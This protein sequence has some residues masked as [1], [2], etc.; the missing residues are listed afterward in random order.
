MK[1]F[2]LSIAILMVIS[3]Y[4]SLPTVKADAAPGDRIVVLGEDLTSQQQNE[5]LEEMGV[6]NPDDVQITTVS[7]ADEHKYLGDHIPAA[8]IGQNAISSAIIIIGEKDDGL[9]LQLK[10]ID[11]ITEQMY[12]NALSTAG[13]KDAKIYI[14]APFQ[15]SGTGALTGIMQAYEITSGEAI[16]EDKKEV[17]NEEMVITSE[18]SDNESIDEEEA[19]DFITLIKTKVSEEKPQSKEDIK[20]LIIEVADEKNYDLSKD[21]IEKLVDLFQ[22]F[23]DLNIDWD[24]VNQ[25]VNDAKGKVTDFLES[26]EGKN[27]IDKITDFFKSLWNLIFGGNDSDTMG[28]AN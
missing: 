12:G 8:Q 21:E 14:T 3:T 25:K 5:I 13:V 27:F 7:N 26:D 24:A 19:A 15:V 10:N 20:Q 16:D 22:K 6:E 18:L 9:S 2:I 23:K 4:V 17:A 11:Y 1:K 28:S